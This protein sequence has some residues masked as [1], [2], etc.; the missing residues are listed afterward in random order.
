MALDAE[1][2]TA[3]GYLFS[4]VS[5]PGASSVAP[6]R[7]T[8]ATP[9]GAPLFAIPWAKCWTQEA[10]ERC[11]EVEAALTVAG[12]RNPSCEL[13]HR[14]STW[15]VLHLLFESQ[16]TPAPVQH[17]LRVTET[18]AQPLMFWAEEELQE[19]RGSYWH[20]EALRRKEQLRLEYLELQEELGDEVSQRLGLSASGFLKAHMA[21]LLAGL[22]FGDKGFVLL[23]GLQGTPSSTSQTTKRTEL[24]ADELSAA[25]G[26][27]L[28]P[29]PG[30]GPVLV[31]TARTSYAA[32]DLVEIFHRGQ[33][34]GSGCSLATFG[35]LPWCSA[36]EEVIVTLRLGPEVLEMGAVDFAQTAGQLEEALQ[37]DLRER[38]PVQRAGQKLTK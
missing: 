2:A 16:T 32:G 4:N 11:P 23:P 1:D 6:L 24:S 15:I 21:L 36:W 26:L 14:S 7:C 27:Q 20:Q 38:P 12:R 19:L 18:G 37:R 29:M 13:L 34:L 8:R 33:C 17:V 30:C 10:A 31:A 5:F 3:L 22:D 9:A 25:Q 28:L 35:S